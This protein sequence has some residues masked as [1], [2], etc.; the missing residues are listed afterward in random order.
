MT[1]RKVLLDEALQAAV[2][3]AV[4]EGVATALASLPIEDGLW[5]PSDS[6]FAAASD[7]PSYTIASQPAMVSGTAYVTRLKVDRTGSAAGCRF[8]VTTAGTALTEASIDL[9]DDS[10][11]KIATASALAALSTLSM[12]NV[13]F[14]SPTPSLSRGDV[15][16]AVLRATFPSGAAPV[17][18]GPSTS[19]FPNVNV[20]GA[21]SRYG[22]IGTGITAPQASIVPA[23]IVFSNIGSTCIWMGLV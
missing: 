14:D 1:V 19:A 18:R 9:F 16:Y 17:L 21:N 7:N 3:A 13:T 10:G 2:D 8:Y 22:T 20:T 5:R 23:S 12:A 6:G 15:L 11:V 4:Q